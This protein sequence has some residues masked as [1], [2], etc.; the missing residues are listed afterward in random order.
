MGAH[1]VL[2]PSGAGAWGACAGWVAMLRL[3]PESC[4]DPEAAAEGTAAHWAA[5][6]MVRGEPVAEGDVDPDGTVIDEDMLEAAG[7]YAADVLSTCAALGIQPIVE[8]P[9]SIPSVHPLCWGT[10][11]AWAYDPREGVLYLWDFKYG[12][13]FVEVFQCRQLV[14]YASGILDLLGIDGLSDQRVRLDARIVQPRSYHRDG[15]IRSWRCVASDLRGLV[16][17]LR[18]AAL[19]AMSDAPTYRPG[20][21]CRDCAGRHACSALQAVALHVVDQASADLPL[22]LPPGALGRELRYLQQAADLLN[23]RLSGL[24]QEALRLLRLG[25]K[26]P[27]WM[28]QQSKGREVWTKPP[29]EVLALGELFGVSLAKDPPALLTPKQ[30]REL[31]DASVINAYSESPRGAMKLV[32]MTETQVA[33]VFTQ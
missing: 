17:Q 19:D 13:R 16:N 28:A 11:D 20:D 30:A 1:S 22:N 27:G 2:P 31:I 32:P 12:H 14:C 24:E 29:A 21:Q 25:E 23:A 10:P 9:V 33:K 7:L 15:P 6:R 4:G 8:A 3:Y 26:V 18:D 5:A